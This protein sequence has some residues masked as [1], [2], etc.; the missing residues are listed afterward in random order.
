[1]FHDV[2]E[3]SIRIE[4]HDIR[5]FRDDLRSLFGMVL[6]DTWLYNDTIME[7]IRYGCLDARRGREAAA[8]LPRQITLY[9][10]CPNPIRWC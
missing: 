8:R 3:G 6:Q 9:A 1:M 10:P 7:N 5:S 2:N 4:G